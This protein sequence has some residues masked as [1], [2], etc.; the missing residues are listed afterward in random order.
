MDFIE[1]LA[2][3]GYFVRLIGAL[4]FGVGAGWL[5]LEAF[6][7]EPYSW[8]LAIAALLGLLLTFVLVGHWVPGGATMGAFGIGAGTAVILWGIAKVGSSNGKGSGTRRR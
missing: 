8:Q 7:R 5:V 4:V 3:L 1:V 6:R 2:V